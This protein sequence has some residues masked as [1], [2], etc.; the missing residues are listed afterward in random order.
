[1]LNQIVVLDEQNMR[2]TMQ[3]IVLEHISLGNHAQ[4]ITC[5]VTCCLAAY[6]VS[7]TLTTC[8]RTLIFECLRKTVLISLVCARGWRTIG[9]HPE[10]ETQFTTELADVAH[11]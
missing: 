5:R 3:K 2:T 7:N 6:Q 1:M 10:G 11:R 8:C 9:H 4:I